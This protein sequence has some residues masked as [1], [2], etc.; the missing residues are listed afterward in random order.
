MDQPTL[1]AALCA[2]VQECTTLSLATV[3]EH[4]EPWAA[5]VNYAADDA[6]NLYFT[7]SPG[8]AHSRHI[9]ARPRVAATAYAPFT[10]PPQIRGVQLR[11]E[12]APIAPAEF[13][14]VW[15]LFL[16]RYPEAAQFESRARSEQFY[17]LTPAWFRLIDNRVHF[18]FKGETD[19]P[20][21]T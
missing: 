17:R 6:L 16:T 7:S 5:N 11:G 1:I 12:V 14:N 3:D 9:A 13:E 20:A 8:S 19:W 4:G 15:R 10:A 18:G 2:V 21:A